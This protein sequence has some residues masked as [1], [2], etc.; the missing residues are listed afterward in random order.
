M[1]KGVPLIIIDNTN[2]QKWEA[3]PY[4][5][6]AQEFGYSVE[7]RET[8][9]PWA[10]DAAELAKRNV[11]GVPLQSI[12]AM[13]ARWEDDFTIENILASQPPRRGGGGGGGPRGSSR[14]GYRGARGGRG[15]ARSTGTSNSSNKN[16]EQNAAAEEDEA[17]V[18]NIAENLEKASLGA[19]NQSD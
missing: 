6:L 2:T 14:G 5:I 18:E 19:K 15:G 3:R 17:E 10:K 8:S 1:K 4:I 7:I 11:H 12:E 13:L 16:E 9:T